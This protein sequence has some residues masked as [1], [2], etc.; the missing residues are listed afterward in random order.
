MNAPAD[1]LTWLPSELVRELVQEHGS[2]LYVYHEPTLRTRCREVAGMLP[3]R[4]FH[5]SV[6]IKTNGNP[7]LLAI[8][9]QEGLGGDAMSPGE[10]L[11][12]ERAG[13]PSKS[14]GQ[15]GRIG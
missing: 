10:I 5:P 2:P 15:F 14:M 11:L 1:H 13:I 6:S 4:D 8:A 12:L 3:G 9:R 7:S